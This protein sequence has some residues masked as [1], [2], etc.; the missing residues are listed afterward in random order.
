MLNMNIGLENII[1]D[2]QIQSQFNMDLIFKL[3]KN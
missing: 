2:K 3:L 1:I